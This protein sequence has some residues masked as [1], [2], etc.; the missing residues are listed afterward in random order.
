MILIWFLLIGFQYFFQTQ[1][2]IK[3]FFSLLIAVALMHS[4]FGI[5]AFWQNW[6]TS[7]GMGISRERAQHLIFNQ[8]NYQINGFFGI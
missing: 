5:L 8:T 7:L 1:K 4:V 2:R 3:R 6:Q